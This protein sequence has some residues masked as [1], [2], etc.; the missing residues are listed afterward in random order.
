MVHAKFG[1][2]PMTAFQALKHLLNE[3]NTIKLSRKVQLR[4]QHEYKIVRSIQ[5]LIC[6]RKDIIIRRTD[7]SKVFYI[8]KA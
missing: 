2:L 3:F 6:H 7:K 8:G 5:Y 4:A 1:S